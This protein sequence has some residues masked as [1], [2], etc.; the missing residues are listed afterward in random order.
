MSTNLSQ[1]PKDLPVPVDDGAAAHLE[2]ALLPDLA[3]PSTDGA[4]VNLTGLGGRW[5]IYI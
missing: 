5:V 3:L 2:G 4:T 1:L